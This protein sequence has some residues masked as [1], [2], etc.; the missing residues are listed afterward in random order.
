MV[1]EVLGT[2]TEEVAADPIE[3]ARAADIASEEASAVVTKWGEYLPKEEL[4]NMAQ[5]LF[6]LSSR[7]SFPLETA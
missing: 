4:Q 1:E 7:I 2:E 6:G 5:V 3:E